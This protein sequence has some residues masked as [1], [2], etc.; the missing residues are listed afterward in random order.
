MPLVFFAVLTD[1]NPEQLQKLTDVLDVQLPVEAPVD[2]EPI[3]EEVADP[4]SAF[5]RTPGYIQ[6][7]IRT[8][9]PRE[10]WEN[11]ARLCECESSFNPRAH[12]SSGEDSRGLWQIN[13]GPGANTDMAELDLFDPLVNAEAAYIVWK[14]HGWRAWAICARLMGV[15][16]TGAGVP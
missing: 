14:R 6:S 11:A 4:D 16:L 2:G 13:I 10:A 5:G 15:P 9:W 8:T 1:V 7:L 12:N 3:A